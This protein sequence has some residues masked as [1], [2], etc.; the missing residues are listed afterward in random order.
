MA[1]RIHLKGTYDYDEKVAAST[2]LPGMLIELT[3]TDKV[4]PH[5]T[6][7]GR[8]ERAIAIEDALSGASVFFGATGRTVATSYVAT[9][10]V[11]YILVHPGGEVLGLLK[12]GTSYVEGDK[13]IS[14]G[15]GKFEKFSAV[16][17]TDVPG[18][19]IAVVKVAIDL[20]VSGAVD[21]LSPIR[22]I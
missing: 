11:P 12:T 13:L 15:N 2:I 20:T 1:N 3:S 5:A 17:S 16:T 18:D 22:I 10:L 4:Q 6:A 19:E 14:A 21:T 7:G 9:D 8:A